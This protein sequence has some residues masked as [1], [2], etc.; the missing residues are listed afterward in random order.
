MEKTSGLEA[1]AAALA[2]IPRDEKKMQ[3]YCLETTNNSG[4]NCP[5]GAYQ[6]VIGL[7]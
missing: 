1:F 3:R 5:K 6:K 2:D 4:H 7:S